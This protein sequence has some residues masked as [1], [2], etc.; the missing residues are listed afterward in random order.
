MYKL[1]KEREDMFRIP[2]F[3]QEEVELSQAWQTMSGHGRG[4]CLEGM[5][6][7]DRIWAEH[8]A[9]PDADDDDFFS[10]W[11]YEVNAYNKVHADM[12]KLFA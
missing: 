11:C 8:C 10:N 7:M 1:K 9:T 4:D 12:S 2:S 5:K 6:S 3:H